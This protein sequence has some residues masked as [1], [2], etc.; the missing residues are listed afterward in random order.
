MS[1]NLNIRI[2]GVELANAQASAKRDGIEWS[3]FVREALRRM[4]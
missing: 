3:E 4:L 2:P 1:A